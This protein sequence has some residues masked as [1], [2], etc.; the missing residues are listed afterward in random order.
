MTEK[1]ELTTISIYKEDLEVLKSL[2]VWGVL[3]RD[4]FHSLMKHIKKEL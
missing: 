2:M 3:I 1:K 4:K